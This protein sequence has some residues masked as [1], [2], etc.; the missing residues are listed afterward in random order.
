M[1]KVKEVNYKKGEVKPTSPYLTLA[2]RTYFI[3]TGVY[4]ESNSLL[5]KNRISTFMSTKIR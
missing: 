1:V 5:E 4:L 3:T 2:W